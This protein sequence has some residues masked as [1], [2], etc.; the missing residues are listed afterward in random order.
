[1][2]TAAISAVSVRP[3]IGLPNSQETH[4]LMSNPIES[5]VTVGARTQEAATTALR[6]WA[7]GV[8]AF[9]GAQSA[10]SEMPDLYARSIDAARSILAGQRQLADALVNAA[11]VAQSVTNQVTRAA[12]QSL[13]ALHA[14]TNGVAGIAH[15]AGEQAEAVAR[16]ARSMRV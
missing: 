14:A 12:E 9:A 8:Q 6:G 2:S 5:F 7:D 3:E 16:S 11:Q 4:E 15:A 13:D 1:V 10:L